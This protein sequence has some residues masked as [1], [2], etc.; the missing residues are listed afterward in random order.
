MPIEIVSVRGAAPDPDVV[1]LLTAAIAESLQTRVSIGPDLRLP[2]DI[3]LSGSQLPSN[4]IVDRLI[5]RA[6]PNRDTFDHLTLAVT[7]HDLY[8]PVRSFVFGEAA[9]GGA[10][11]VVSS[12]RLASPIHDSNILHDRL[13][14]EAVHELGHLVGLEHCPHPHCVMHPSTSVLE[15]DEKVSE[16]C[17]SCRLGLSTSNGP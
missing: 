7:S 13:L 1:R 6:G 10:W 11:A 5:E 16:F 17:P 9:F 4:A 8:A 3:P 12:A 14:K 15:I 2:P